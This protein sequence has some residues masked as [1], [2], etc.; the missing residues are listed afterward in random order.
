MGD[1]R[2][3]G[4]RRLLVMRHAKAE[5]VAAT[6]HGRRLTERGRRDAAEAGRW[7]RSANLVPDH[8][9][10][11]DAARALDTWA[12]FRAG[13]ELV[14]EAEPV[15]G[16]YPAGTDA[17]LEILRTAPAGVTTL[18]VVG[19]NPTMAQLVSQS[20][21]PAIVPRMASR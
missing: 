19:H 3:A 7:A 5:S 4:S 13:A 9:L 18:M 11:S 6:D 1:D 20:P 12:A 16:L 15:A 2:A 10:V 14:V 21:S 17:A 8:V